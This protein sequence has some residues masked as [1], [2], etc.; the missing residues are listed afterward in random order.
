MR[1]HPVTRRRA[2]A[3]LF[4]SR[5]F[6]L[7]VLA[8]VFAA[9]ALFFAAGWYY[10][11]EIEDRA[12]TAHHGP[13]TFDLRVTSIA[14]DR[15]TLQITP[16]TASSGRWN[17]PGLWGLES[18]DTYNQVSTI[19]DASD[20]SVVRELIAL[21]P[22]PDV[23]DHVRIDS[24]TYPVDPFISHGIQFQEVGVP[25]DLGTFPAWLT[26]GESDT[27]VILVHGQGADRRELL[28]ILPIFV[29]RGYPTLTITYRNDEGLPSSPRGYYLFGVEEW[30]DLS[31]AA[32][33]A[34]AEGGKD[35]ILVG[36]S[37]GGAVVASFLYRSP[38]ADRVR[39]VVLDAPALSLGDII[40]F[41]GARERVFGVPLPGLL[42]G[43]AKSLSSLRFGIEY[44]AM[45]Y[46]ERAGQLSTPV[47]LFHGSDDLSVPAS[48]SDRLARARPDIVEYHLFRGAM[49]V[50]SWN[51]DSERYR[52]AVRSFL[53]GLE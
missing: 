36:C 5:R 8:A 6:Q 3:I 44:G 24:Y 42:T 43:L 16:D 53:D 26:D 11:G 32:T 9:L 49:H 39:G 52:T 21:G 50:G 20:D 7:I 30:E 35:L 25:A 23:G 45:D 18:A 51:L 27:W 14:G 29:E 38:D 12:F 22:L 28:R 19:F 47:L 37:M 46:L 33:F 48:L 15:I 2:G 34:F 31:A 41:R 10:S 1:H 4:R 13:D 40:D 17:K